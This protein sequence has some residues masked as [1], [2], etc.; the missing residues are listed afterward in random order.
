MKGMDRKAVRSPVTAPGTLA[1]AVTPR[2]PAA[3]AGASERLIMNQTGHRSV[4]IVRKY[5][6]DGQ[7]FRENA[8]ATVGW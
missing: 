3:E 6:R 4:P 7:L 5:I 1:S 2:R 8:A